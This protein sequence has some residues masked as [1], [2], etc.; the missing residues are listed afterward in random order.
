MAFMLTP[1]FQKVETLPSGT[2]VLRVLGT[3]LGVLGAPASICILVGMA[4]FCVSGNRSSVGA[5]ILWCAL[6]LSTACFGAVAYYVA[7]YR[8][9]AG[10][11][12][13]R[14]G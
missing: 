3:A 10:E 11:G 12:H 5:K 9:E 13:Q 7:I 2:M 14:M 1:W 8:K 6:F 4:L